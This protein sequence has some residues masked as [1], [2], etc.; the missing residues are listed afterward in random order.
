MA[1]TELKELKEQLEE[2]L[3]QGYSS[4]SVSLWGAPVLF[5]KKKNSTM[6][7]CIDYRGLNT[8]TVK[9]KYPLSLIDKLF[10]QL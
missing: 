9:N 2:L 1:P 7:L 4:P 3:K 8:L 6:R 5:L 10:D